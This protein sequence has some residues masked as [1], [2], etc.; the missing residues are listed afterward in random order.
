[1]VALSAHHRGLRT[2][3]TKISPLGEASILRLTNSGRVALEGRV[4]DPTG[5]PVAGAD[6]HLRSRERAAPNGP[7]LGY[8]TIEFE[9]GYVLVTD[10]DGRFRT[11]KELDPDG[12]YAAYASAPGFDDNRPIWTRG[13]AGS[14]PNLTLPP[15]ASH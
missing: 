2:T 13:Q 4:I 7:V 5:R 3:E 11:P 14:F 6:V 8:E 15:S 9:N 12:E 1:V 10:A